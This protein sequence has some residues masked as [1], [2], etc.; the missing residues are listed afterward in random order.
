ME[1]EWN[2]TLVENILREFKP[3]R[4]YILK[5]LH[6]LQDS[7]PQQYLPEETLDRVAKYFNLTRG[8]VFGIVTYYTMFSS[9]PREKNIARICKSPVCHSKGSTLLAEK[10]QRKKEILGIPNLVIEYSECLGQCHR[11][12]VMLLNQEIQ[13]DL[14][15][16]KLD[17]I[18][19]SLKENNHESRP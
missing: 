16:E 9:K 11:A 6:R 19:L 1:S 8:Q 3:Q 13:A 12:P 14:T 4:M 2:P 5:A 10:L 15:D 17:E 18:L 7:H